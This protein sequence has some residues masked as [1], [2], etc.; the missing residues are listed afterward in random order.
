VVV[1][2]ASEVAVVAADR[3][4]AGRAAAGRAAAV[5]AGRQIG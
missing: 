2:G 4:A 1:A 5:I 3:V